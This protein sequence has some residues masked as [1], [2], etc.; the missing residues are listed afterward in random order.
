M[1]FGKKNCLC[2]AKTIIIYH[3]SWIVKWLNK[4]AVHSSDIN[5]AHAGVKVVL[6]D[7]LYI[8]TGTY[9]SLVVKRP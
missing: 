3:I 5:P 7:T 8:P 4:T 1:L 9:Y 2:T 6:H